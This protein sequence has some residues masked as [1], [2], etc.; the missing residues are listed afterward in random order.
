MSDQFEHLQNPT[1]NPLT[2]TPIPDSQIAT[3]TDLARDL[4]RTEKAIE[5]T[6]VFLEDLKRK[7]AM[8]KMQLIPAAM[9]KIGMEA[10]TLKSKE[11]NGAV[12]TLKVKPF[13]S[14][15]IAEENETNAFKW[16]RDNDHAGMVRTQFQIN[17]TQKEQDMVKKVLSTLRRNRI[18]F[19][20][21]DNVHWQT[22]RAWVKTMKEGGHFIPD[23]LFGV[24]VGKTTDIKVIYEAN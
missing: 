17:L 21:K 6:E 19:D 20:K 13:Y 23:D 4:Y 22:L 3:I 8:L 16:L 10:F 24:F 1:I 2:Q 15:K 12:A 9:E 7:Q 14:A 5:K 18:P 11:D